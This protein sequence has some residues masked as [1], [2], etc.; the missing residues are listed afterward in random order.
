VE[1][2]CLFVFTVTISHDESSPTLDIFM[3]PT[4]SIDIKKRIIDLRREGLIM[5]DIATQMKVSVGSVH[6]A[7]HTYEEC[8]E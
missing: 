3:S 4:L 2:K 6:K 8:G 1:K 5:R 7:L